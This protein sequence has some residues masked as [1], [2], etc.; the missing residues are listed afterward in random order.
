MK[1]PQWFIF[2]IVVLITFMLCLAINFRAFSEFRKQATEYSELNTEIEKLT[3]N[4][5]VLQE[6]IQD[7]KNDDGTIA[8]E[9]RKIGMSRS[10]EKVLVPK[11]K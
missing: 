11:S 3:T 10:N 5:L 8:R 9:A 2:T 7:L 6:E 1:T 4:N